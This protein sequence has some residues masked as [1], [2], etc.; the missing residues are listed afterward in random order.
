MVQPPLV[1]TAIGG[2]MLPASRLT[3]AFRAAVALAAITARANPEKRPATRIAAKPLPENYF[4][5]NRH[6]HT[7]A[8]FDNDS[9]S[10]QGK[11]N[12]GVAFV[13]A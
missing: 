13:L 5:M 3:A 11:A 2:P 9:G 10:C 1:M 8:D 4:P 7:Q 12:S 6:P